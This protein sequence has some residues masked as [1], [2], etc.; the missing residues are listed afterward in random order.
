MLSSSTTMIFKLFGSCLLVASS[1]NASVAPHTMPYSMYNIPANLYIKT[2][3]TMDQIKDTMTVLAQSDLEPAFVQDT[4]LGL[5]NKLYNNVWTT[6]HVGQCV[7][8]LF[9]LLESYPEPTLEPIQE[10]EKVNDNEPLSFEQGAA[11]VFAGWVASILYDSVGKDAILMLASVTWAVVRLLWKIVSFIVGTMAYV[12]FAVVMFLANETV[13]T[14]QE[15]A[16]WIGDTIYACTIGIVITIAKEIFKVAVYAL[17]LAGG[18]LIG[19]I[20]PPLVIPYAI[21]AYRRLP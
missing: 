15:V 3:S 13:A 16:R 17:V 5:G 14:L 7:P 10:N 9:D 12:L 19:L 21:I 18:L 2:T 4:V 6:D 8:Q 20:C 1:A 11:M